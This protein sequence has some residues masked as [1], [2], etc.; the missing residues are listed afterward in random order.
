MYCFI[1]LLF[2]LVERTGKDIAFIVFLYMVTFI[3]LSGGSALLSGLTS[4]HLEEPPWV[5]L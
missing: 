4:F 5:F 2:K 1:Q 3:V